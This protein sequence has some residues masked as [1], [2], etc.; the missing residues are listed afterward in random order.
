MNKKEDLLKEAILEHYEA[1]SQ[2]EIKTQ[3]EARTITESLGYSAQDL[4]GLPQEADLGLGCGNPHERAKPQEG[5]HVLDLGSGRGLD[6]FIAAKAVGKTGRVVG[7][8]ALASMVEKA[9]AI[10]EKQGF[11]QCSFVQGEIE[12]IP[13]PDNSFDLVISNCVINL[14]LRKPTVYREIFRVLKPGGRVAISDITTKKAL[15]AEW[16]ADP[17]MAKT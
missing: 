4:E 8:D 1:L 10:A 17:H 13:S 3:E 15:P 12:D 11:D 16:V 6:C 14:S 2:E 5:E 9:T 7:V